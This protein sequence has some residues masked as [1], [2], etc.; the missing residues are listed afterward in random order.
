MNKGSWIEIEADLKRRK[1]PAMR[2]EVGSFQQDFKARAT[3]MRQEPQ[4]ET[5]LAWFPVLNWRYMIPAAAAL[6]IAWLAMWPSPT[7]LVTQV[8]SLQVFAPHSA[9]IIMVDEK[10]PGTVVW[11]TDLESGDGNTG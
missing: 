1:T 9:V 5:A 3:L 7:S 6:M 4:T 8:K 11:V 10:E 2:R